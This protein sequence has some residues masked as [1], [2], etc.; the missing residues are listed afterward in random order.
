MKRR[1]LCRLA[2]ICAVI[3]ATASVP[4]V[5]QAA[6]LSPPVADCNA[7]AQI[8]GHYSVAELRNALATMPAEIKEYTDCADVIERQLLAQVGS[9]HGDG[10]SGQGGGSFLP[11][12]LIV[13][14]ALLVVAGAG[15]GVYSWQRARG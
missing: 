7:H 15:F 12:P 9:L 2:V 14:L 5:S 13:V 11:T 3:A 8:T 4:A 10:G 6:G 1:P